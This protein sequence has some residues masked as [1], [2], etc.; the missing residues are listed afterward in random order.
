MHSYTYSEVRNTL[1]PIVK[2]I[3]T[4]EFAGKYHE[5]ITYLDTLPKEALVDIMCSKMDETDSFIKQLALTIGT[6][7][8]PSKILGNFPDC[9]VVFM[10]LRYFWLSN[11][12]MHNDQNTVILLPEDK[13]SFFIELLINTWKIAL[14]D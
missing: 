13:Q 2:N 4:D 12:L 10:Y 5:T 11:H 1:Y 7:V 14:P 3:F 6:P 9:I 8:G